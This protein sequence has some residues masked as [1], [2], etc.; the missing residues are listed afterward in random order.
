[1]TEHEV[2]LRGGEAVA[3]R[4]G[5]LSRVHQASALDLGPEAGHPLLHPLLVAGDALPEPLEL[6]PVGLQT[7]AEHA[8]PRPRRGPA[9]GDDRISRRNCHQKSKSS[10]LPLLKRV[11][12]PRMISPFAPI[13][14][15]P[16]L[17]ALNFSPSAPLIW[18]EARA[19]AAYPAR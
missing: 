14:R 7:D 9:A 2:H 16:S 18:P 19:A 3:R 8:D 10:M 15:D 6:V 4:P 1:M 5:L 17:P 12:G 11:G 13:V